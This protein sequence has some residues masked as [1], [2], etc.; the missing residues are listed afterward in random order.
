MDWNQIAQNSLFNRNQPNVPINPAAVQMNPNGSFA[1]N[2][3][4]LQSQMGITPDL[5]A[6][7]AGYKGPEAER[8][9]NMNNYLGNWG[10][11]Y[12]MYGGA[13]PPGAQRGIGAMPWLNVDP[14]KATGAQ[15]PYN[16]STTGTAPTQ[17]GPAANPNVPYPS[18]GGGGKGSSQPPQ[19]GGGKGSSMSPYR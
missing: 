12:Q 9:F 4:S 6:F 1:G 7:N 15:V 18:G 11:K 8:Q 3:Q 5:T 10:S 17:P 19:Q 13:P 2:L 14:Y 16:P